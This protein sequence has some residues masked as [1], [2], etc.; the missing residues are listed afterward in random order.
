MRLKGRR[1]NA[2]CTI[3]EDR[4]EGR[5]GAINNQGIVGAA[6]E[7]TRYCIVGTI[8]VLY[9]LV[10]TIAKLQH[11]VIKRCTERVPKI[12]DRF[13]HTKVY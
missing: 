1:R 10:H 7:R 11:V 13:Y 6:S 5:R 4:S 3:G 9:N 12:I 8:R 2:Y